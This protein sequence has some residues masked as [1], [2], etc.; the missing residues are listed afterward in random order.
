MR[1]LALRGDK[2]LLRLKPTLI[3]VQTVMQAHVFLYTLLAVHLFDQHKFGV[4]CQCLG[5][6][7]CALAV[8]GT[9]LAITPP[10]VRKFMSGEFVYYVLLLVAFEIGMKGNIFCHKNRCRIRCSIEAPREG[11]NF[12][13]ANRAERGRAKIFLAIIN[14]TLKQIII[15][16]VLWPL[17]VGQMLANP[18]Y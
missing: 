4:H 11:G 5:E 3:Q 1:V 13:K 16:V 12:G 6:H 15:A 7:C 9:D 8:V 2:R 14:K 18:H 17:L 10:L